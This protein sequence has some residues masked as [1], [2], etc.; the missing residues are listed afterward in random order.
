MK[1]ILLLAL[2]VVLVSCKDSPKS[3]MEFNDRSSGN[4]LIADLSHPGKDLL[5]KQCYICHNPNSA[6]NEMIAP[7]MIAIKKHYLNEATS[8]DQF[9]KE[10]MNWVKNPS[11]ENSKMP[12]ALIK[13]G[14]M[15][16]QSFPEETIMEIS[17][18]LY[19]YDIDEPVWFQTQMGKGQGK[20][21]GNKKEKG[22]GE[23]SANCMDKG[24]A[25]CKH[26]SSIVIDTLDKY[27]KLGQKYA[28]EAKAALGKKLMKAITEKG[29]DGAVEFCSASALPLT[30]SLSL[31]YGAKIR[32]I[33]D[34]PRNPLNKVNEKELAFIG[35]F[36]EYLVSDNPV[37]P[38]LSL[39]DGHVN[40]YYP[41]I[42]NAMCLQCHGKSKEQ[43]ATS[44]LVLLNKLYPDDMAR[45]YQENEV[46]GMWAIR[47]E[48]Q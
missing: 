5:E 33:T 34:K 30:D 17:E 43:I 19:D 27:K 8:R 28:S 3:T 35:R 6:Q 13:F 46:R 29:P 38:I 41:I 47:F 31:M 10:I 44:T 40:F 32:R 4:E 20:G 9:V 18:Y 26:M 11:K 16:Y 36:K 48:G 15:P 45:E 39:T 37:E 23:C 1:Y 24:Q 22:V 21:K 12:G 25:G 2:L 7:P 42:T 14:I